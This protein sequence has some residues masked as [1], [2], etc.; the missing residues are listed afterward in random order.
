MKHAQSVAD[1]S[2][3]DDW[4]EPADVGSRRYGWTETDDL[5][6]AHQRYEHVIEEVIDTRLADWDRDLAEFGGDPAR[7]DWTHFRPLRLA[8]EEDWSDWLAFLIDT[9]STGIIAHYLFGEPKSAPDAYARPA[10]VEREVLAE[11]YRADLVVRW[12]DG[13]V[14]HV[15]VKIGDPNLEKTVETAKHLQRVYDP[16]NVRWADF[17]LLLPVQM[18]EWDSLVD[19]TEFNRPVACITWQDVSIGLRRGLL[20]EESV[21]WKSFA[22]A[23]VGAIEQTLL[24]FASPTNRIVTTGTV[25]LQLRVLEEGRYHE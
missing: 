12:T 1:W 22:L 25:E 18:A 4:G 8:R 17:I 10:R 14:A 2:I 19:R 6:K 3:F 7:T 23:F 13:A 5:L 20:G 24:R 21:L 15:E 11:P 9:S 16:G